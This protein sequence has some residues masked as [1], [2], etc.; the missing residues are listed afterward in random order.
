M[1]YIHHTGLYYNWIMPLNSILGLQN[2][3]LIYPPGDDLS[4]QVSVENITHQQIDTNMIV[5]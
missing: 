1:R 4:K 2:G 3:P 5:S